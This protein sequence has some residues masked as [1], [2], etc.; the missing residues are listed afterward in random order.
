MII[1]SQSGDKII[2]WSKVN[3]VYLVGNSV[4]IGMSDKD[5]STYGKYRTNEQ[6]NLVLGR[7][8]YAL[9]E[10]EKQFQFPQTKRAT[11]QQGSLWFGRR[12]KTWRFLTMCPKGA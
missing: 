7:L 11:G 1:M 6:A 10:G 12:Q 8:F 2:D 9:V 3:K 5:Y 4:V